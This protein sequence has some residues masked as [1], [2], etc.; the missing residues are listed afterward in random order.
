MLSFLPTGFLSLLGPAS[1]PSHET[2]H[3]TALNLPWSRYI[4]KG[5]ELECAFLAG[6]LA[7]PLREE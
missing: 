2:I 6:D 4:F 3:N 5:S 7:A 1:L